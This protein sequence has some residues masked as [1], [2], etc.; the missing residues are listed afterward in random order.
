MVMRTSLPI[1]SQ[2]STRG[3]TSRSNGALDFA[4]DMIALIRMPLWRRLTS[5]QV[6]AHREERQE[7]LRKKGFSTNAI[8]PSSS[9]LIPK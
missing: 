3:V 1:L 4:L 5:K 7:Y 8:V 6:L 9:P 2:A